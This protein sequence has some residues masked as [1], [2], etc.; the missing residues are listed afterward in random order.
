MVGLL[1]APLRETELLP[2][3]RQQQYA[4]YLQDP[5]NDAPIAPKGCLSVRQL[6]ALSW[7]FVEAVSLRQ[8]VPNASPTAANA[9]SVVVN[10]SHVE[11]PLFS[12]LGPMPRRTS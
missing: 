8:G 4:Q 11:V 10:F 1:N 12:A 9:W 7:E 3:A 5:L 6:L 2:I